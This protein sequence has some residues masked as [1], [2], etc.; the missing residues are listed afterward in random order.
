MKKTALVFY[1]TRQ[2]RYSFNSLFGSLETNLD[3]MSQVDVYTCFKKDDLYKT[4]F[5][6]V[7]KYKKVVLLISFFTTQFFDVEEVIKNVRKD[8]DKK[9]ICI[10]GGPHPTGSPLSTLNLGFDLVVLGEAEEVF[11]KLI[12]KMLKDEEYFSL[13]NIAYFDENKGLIINKRDEKF[14][15]LD[16]FPPITKHF[17]HYGPIE[18]TRGCPYRCNF[19]QTSQIFGTKLRHRSVEKVCEYIEIM[20][21][22]GLADTR[23]ITPSLFLYGSKTGKDLNLSKIEELFKN[24]KGIIKS[25]GKLFVGTFPSE[26]RPEHINKDTI[27]ILKKYADNDNVIL[28]AQSGSERILKLANR[29]HTLD[30]VCN[31]VEFLTKANFKVNLDFIFGLPYETKDDVIKTIDFIDK[32]ISK[33]RVR[34]HAHYF[35]PLPGTKFQDCLPERS[36][37]LY[38]KYSKELKSKGVIY[39]N[40]EKQIQFLSILRKI[41][42]NYI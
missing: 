2:N 29:G 6:I 41:S 10:A 23:F 34:I 4:L 5:E 20:L 32:L 28:G 22:K 24:V 31:A 33:Y 14:V 16:K 12:D 36:S 15:D 18:I 21:S 8:F 13:P 37:N 42:K 30:D 38:L 7:G 17:E 26:I 3:I 40:W 19:C 39:G 27:E 11:L 1:Y 25:K 9:V 35:I